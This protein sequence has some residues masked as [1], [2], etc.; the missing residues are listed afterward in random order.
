MRVCRTPRPA[1]A[2]SIIGCAE[3][4]AVVRSTS[5]PIDD[6][7]ASADVATIVGIAVAVAVGFAVAVAVDDAFAVAVGVG[8][9]VAVCV[10][11][12]EGDAA[13]EGFGDAEAVAVD[14]AAIATLWVDELPFAATGALAPVVPA[15][16]HPA[17]P[18]N[19]KRE[20]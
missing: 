20:Q 6:T 10:G 4:V 9:G 5:T 14:V 1:K 8:F 11:D 2:L 13:A 18:M 3:A 12:A 7:N 17:K 19:I 15:A 16:L